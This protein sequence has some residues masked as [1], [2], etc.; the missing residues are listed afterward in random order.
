M[1]LG[2]ILIGPLLLVLAIIFKLFPPKNRNWLYGYRTTRSMK[3]QEAWDASNRYAMQLMLW[4]AIVT[5]VVQGGMYVLI[6]P[7]TALLGGTVVMC[8]LLVAI[9]PITEKYLKDNFDKNGEIS[10]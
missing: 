1:L 7:K 5:S 3:S 10:K 2:N 9:I 8:L 4:V 6:N